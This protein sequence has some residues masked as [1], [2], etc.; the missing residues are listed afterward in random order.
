MTYVSYLF[1]QTLWERL[2]IWW[3]CPH[4]LYCPDFFVLRKNWKLT[5][6]K[7]LQNTWNCIKLV[8][9]SKILLR[10][11]ETKILQSMYIW[12]HFYGKKKISDQSRL[13]NSYCIGIQHV[14]KKTKTFLSHRSKSRPHTNF[15]FNTQ[16]HNTTTLYSHN[17]SLLRKVLSAFILVLRKKSKFVNTHFV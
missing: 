15:I 9:F 16:Y 4:F 14:S 11:Y 7:S 5:E 12:V 10:L 13:F 6:D 17:S 8:L 2:G 3:L 1:L